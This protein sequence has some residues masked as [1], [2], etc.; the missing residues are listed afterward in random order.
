MGSLLYVAFFLSGVSGLI[1]QI[2]WVRQFGNVL[3]NTVH[4]AALVVAV[5]ML[6]LGVGS[7]VAGVWADRRRYPG[8]GRLLRAY[9]AAEVVLAALGLGVSLLV[10]RL[11]ALVAGWSS[12]T[13]GTGGWQELSTASHA[14]HAAAVI[15]LLTPVTV[16]MGATLT[17]LIRHLVRVDVGASGWQIARLYGANTVGAAAGAVLADF[18]L[19]RLA[20]L[21]ATQVAAAGLNLAAA[22]I[23]AWAL[24][25]AARREPA[26]DSGP[27]GSVARHGGSLSGAPHDAGNRP[28]LVPAAA[29]CVGLSGVA[30]MGMEMVWVRHLG[31]LLG[32]FRAVFSL[33][34][35]VLLAAN[36]LGALAGG[37]LLRRWRRP[38]ELLAAAQALFVVSAL[39]GLAAAD[40]EALAEKGRAIAAT[41]AALGPLRRALA[42]IGFNLGP[43]LREVAVPAFAAGL[44]FPL[45]NALVQR[46][47]D[48]IGRRAGLLYF[49]N[50]A[51][52]VAGSLGAGYVL[53][54]R[55]G[56]QTTAA[57]LALV[58]AAALVPLLA[59]GAS[60]RAT[61]LAAAPAALALA[62]WTALPADFVVAR[63]SVV[64]RGDR[65]LARGEGLTE[66]VAVVEADRGRA[67]LTNGHAMSS[68]ALLDQRYMR[69]LA[70]VPLLSM[71]APRRVLV[72]GFGVGNTAHA[73]TLHPTV[74]RVDVAELSRQ[75]LAHAAYFRS[76]TGDVLHDPK[77]Q[78]FLNDGRQHLQMMPAATY[79]LV[80]LEPP[81]VAHAGVAALYSRQFYELVRSRLTAGGYISQWLPAY[82]VPI[83]SSLAMVRAFVD[84]F[85][86]T[87]LLSGAQA[88]L[89]LVGTTGPRVEI[90]PAVL[91]K[92]M[93]R[94]PAAAAD[95]G[96]LDLGHP[97]EIVGAFV[98]AAATLRDAT[99]GSPPATDDRPVQ[100]YGVWSGLSTGLHGVPASLF[101]LDALPA[102][103]PRC[104]DGGRPVPSVDGLDAYLALLREAYAAPPGAVAAAAAAGG[105]RRTFLGSRYL[106]LVLPD[107]AEVYNVVGA[108]AR[109]QGRIDDAARAF[110]AALQLEPASV[111][112]R[113]NLGQIRH[114]QGRA[115]LEARRFRDAAAELRGAVTLMPQS[116]AAHND[117]GV[118]LAS[119]NE[120]A[121]AAAQFRAAVALNPDFV[122]AR[123]NLSAAE[124]LVP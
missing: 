99:R 121:E 120:V 67:L 11:A 90:D 12:Y 103:C 47:V 23:A 40:A 77:V 80:T 10:P 105:P 46:S 115:L 5:F 119:V 36:G 2:T 102:W 107:T 106:G 54:P 92:T 33:V 60:R 68:T 20:G 44:S 25:G 21:Q 52:A 59:A 50:T 62:A 69:A 45:A 83:E 74:E 34:L 91:D 29:L 53:L 61:M 104:F 9:V 114:E 49:A 86:E 8:D 17:L 73:A 113:Q 13:I 39:A 4:S 58:A 66:V 75:V 15:V 96:R 97:R 123:R 95:L 71:A 24:R 18:A 26:L 43:A 70:H 110:A 85:P 32:G 14:G 65:V 51:G 37:W 94:R 93:A 22:A 118:A 79:D 63:A 76:S 82:Q 41:L 84:V 124:A 112:A 7:Y 6:G 42:E 87:V 57:M 64:P 122:E 72:I 38:A 89:L 56:M 101:D 48:T 81:P 27:S 109:G 19:V 16:T 31:I 100:E 98:G 116:A 117:L 35:A 78:V 88:E 1:Y 55:L 3:G 28:L 30:V 108:A 111:A